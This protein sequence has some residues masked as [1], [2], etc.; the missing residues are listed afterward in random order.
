MAEKEL[1]LKS[2]FEMTDKEIDQRI[3]RAKKG[4]ITF[5]FA[6]KEKDRFFPK[7]YGQA[8]M[9]ISDE[10]I[11]GRYSA[12]DGQVYESKAEWHKSFSRN[13]IEMMPVGAKL[14]TKK[15]DQI[16]DQEYIDTVNEAERML[17]WK[18]VPVDEAEKAEKKT[19]REAMLNKYGT[20]QQRKSKNKSR[21][22]N[23]E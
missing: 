8:P 2:L 23:G 18:E 17:D 15:I 21:I 9:I 11:G 13:G 20:E 22:I 1:F 12:A 19:I 4:V 16:A 10:L 5:K 3:K 14:P 7:R 6:K